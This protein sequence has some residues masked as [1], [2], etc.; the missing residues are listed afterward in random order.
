MLKRKSE[1]YF[2]LKHSRN[3]TDFCFFN[4]KMTTKIRERKAV[5]KLVSGEFEASLAENFQAENYVAGASKSPKIQ[6]DR[7]DEIKTS[8][9]K[10]DLMSDLT[11]ILAEN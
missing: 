3:S 9:R 4:I 1:N 5:A 11:K 10:L 7:L 6:S 2:S 8:L